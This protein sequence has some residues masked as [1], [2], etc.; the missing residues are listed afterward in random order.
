MRAGCLQVDTNLLIKAL[1]LG[2][3]HREAIMILAHNITISIS[4]VPVD[5]HLQWEDRED[6]LIPT[7]LIMGKFKDH[8]QICIGKIW[9]RICEVIGNLNK[10]IE[11]YY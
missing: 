4:K 11:I 3:T 6:K 10:S 9:V 7:E 2:I 1:E 8:Q 5:T